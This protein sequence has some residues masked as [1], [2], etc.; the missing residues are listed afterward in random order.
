[1]KLVYDNLGRSSVSFRYVLSLVSREFNL[2][3]ATPFKGKGDELSDPQVTKKKKNCSGPKHHN[4]F[5]IVG[6]S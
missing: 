5:P 3:L 2:L 6:S 4:F 1:M